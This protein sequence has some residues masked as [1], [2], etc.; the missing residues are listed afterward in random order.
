MGSIE[1]YDY[2][3]QKWVPY[4]S[5]PEDAERFFQKME[6]RRLAKNPQYMTKK[7]RDMEE[8][9]I[10]TEKKLA[11]AEAKLKEKTPRVTQVTP[12]AQAIEM[13]Q[14]QV[15]RERKKTSSIPQCKKSQEHKTASSIPQRTLKKL[16]KYG[17]IG[18]F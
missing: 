15:D 8:K 6:A 7:L 17:A 5:T 18:P 2:K 1:V 3:Q 14:A 12:V 10:D 4:V 13:A 9:L 11:E 16:K